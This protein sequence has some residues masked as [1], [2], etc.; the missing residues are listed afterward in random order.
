M[1][2][3]FLEAKIAMRTK[4]P[5][6]GFTL[7]PIIL[8]KHNGELT[9]QNTK[10]ILI[11]GQEINNTI[12]VPL[13]P[14]IKLLLD[15]FITLP[16]LPKSIFIS[17]IYIIL[18][19]NTYICYDAISVKDGLDNKETLTPA[20]FVKSIKI[21]KFIN[22]DLKKIFTIVKCQSTQLSE[23]AHARLDLKKILEHQSNQ[24]LQSGHV[25]LDVDFEK[26]DL[27]YKDNGKQG[28]EFIIHQKIKFFRYPWGEVIKVLPMPKLPE[29]GNAPK[30]GQLFGIG[31]DGCS[32]IWES[33]EK[34]NTILRTPGNKKVFIK[35]EPGSGK[36]VFAHSIH[37]GSVRLKPVNFVVRSVAGAN[38]Q[39]LRELLFGRQVDGVSLPG[40]IKKADGGTLFLD[41]F[42]KIKGKKFYSEL[43]RVLEAEEYVPVD[44]KEI[45]KVGDVN[46]IFAGAFMGTG[47][48]NAISDLPQDFWSRLTSYIRIK[49]P[50]QFQLTKNA[51]IKGTPSNNSYAKV[52]FLYFFLQEAVEKG[53]GVD[54]VTTS[55]EGD[56][57]SGIIRTLF[58]NHS[59]GLLKPSEQ[60][61]K[62]A[63]DFD[64]KISGGRYPK[65]AFPLF[66]RKEVLLDSVRS[67]RQAAKIAFSKCYYSALTAEAPENWWDDDKIDKKDQETALDEAVESVKIARKSEE[68]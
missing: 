51:K 4:T 25:H 28:Y 22:E 8:L 21:N 3:G 29:P 13:D 30:H 47:V 53:E 61:L 16:R 34:L 39:E 55:N 46:W 45:L 52:I 49:N 62:F 7:N 38:T 18:E 1:S 41:E 6:F 27:N 35:G 43:L 15:D 67:I 19:G 40:L 36:E 32:E 31:K 56:F 60:L 12:K 9:L 24:L 48:S 42:D 63:N 20:L 14:N 37:Y 2:I 17:Y 57:R 5:I 65:T 23:K 10:I 59:D 50:I 44:G 33:I 54:N 68:N 26:I 11:N 64:E 58:I 66:N